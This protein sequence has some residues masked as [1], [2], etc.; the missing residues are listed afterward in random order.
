MTYAKLIDN[1]PQFAPRHLTAGDYVVYNPPA[2]IYL[3]QGWLPVRFTEAPEA[4]PGWHYEESW[5][6]ES[7]E[8]VQGWELVRDPDDISAD[9][10]MEI[11]LGGG[12]T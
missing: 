5:A 9:E 4:E 2:E 11:I 3:E 1:Y 7:G 8:I 12:A 10:A 6:E